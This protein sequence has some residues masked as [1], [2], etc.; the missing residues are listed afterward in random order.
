MIQGLGVRLSHSLGEGLGVRLRGVE[1]SVGVLA[2]MLMRL[3]N[4]FLKHFTPLSLGEGLGGEAF[5]YGLTDFPP[6]VVVV[7]VSTAP[8]LGS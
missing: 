1:C 3:I 6:G 4:G 5:F 2:A 8:L 7:P